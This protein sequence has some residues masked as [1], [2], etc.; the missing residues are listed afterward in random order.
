M[1]FDFHAGGG[2]IDKN[3]QFLDP[4]SGQLHASVSQTGR[5][6]AFRERFRESYVPICYYSAHTVRDF[7]V[8][9]DA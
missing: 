6:N 7:L 8:I 2:R 1:S 9:D 3:I 5:G 4:D